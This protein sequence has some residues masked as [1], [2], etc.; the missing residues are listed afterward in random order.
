MKRTLLTYVLLLGLV[1]SPQRASSQEIYDWEAWRQSRNIAGLSALSSPRTMIAGKTAA[2]SAELLGGYTSGGFHGGSEA[3]ELWQ[4]GAKVE[5]EV[6][7]PSW[8]LTGNLS[9]VR[10]SGDKMC[11]SLFTQPGYFP[12]DVLE[13]APGRK[14]LQTYAA[15]GGLAWQSDSPWILGGTL[16][17][18]GTSSSKRET[19][20]HTTHR[21]DLEAV[22]SVL[23]DENDWRIGASYI[24]RTISESVRAGQSGSDDAVFLDKGMMYGS[25]Q[26]WDGTVRE[27]THGFAVQGELGDFLYGDAEWLFSR[28]T[29][30]E[31][32]DTGFRFPGRAFSAQLIYTLQRPSGVHAFRLGY[33]GSRQE[34]EDDNSDKLYERRGFSVGPSWR[35]YR[36][37][38]MEFGAKFVIIYGKDLGSILPSFLD[39]DE[40]TA[41]EFEAD[42]VLPLGRFQ[43][44]AGMLYGRLLGD[45]RHVIDKEN[46]D[47]SPFRLEDWWDREQEVSD[48]TRLG[49]SF[50]LRYDFPLRSVEGLFLEASCSFVHAFGIELLP[51]ADRQETLFT[52]GYEF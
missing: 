3:Q 26:A 41:C 48:A 10:Q 11:G 37:N 13:F 38:G 18:E 27:I 31:K 8:L 6:H 39:H 22:P 4:A 34:L 44:S 47:D 52:L 50:A 1:C 49:G 5:T 32:G 9:F 16:R 28:G 45:H 36:G 21:V 20:R 17:F 51:G 19:F 7:L 33:E 24:F 42:A 12:F 43:L 14:T 2:S 30:G 40:S 29:A 15:G 35:L 23:Y 25:Y 46:E